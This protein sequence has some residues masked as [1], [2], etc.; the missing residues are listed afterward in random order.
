[1]TGSALKAGDR[2]SGSTES[3]AKVKFDRQIVAIA[4][5]NHAHAIFSDDENIRKFAIANGVNPIAIW[6][7]PLPPVDAQPTLWEH[8]SDEETP[9]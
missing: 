8:M 1:M 7:L 4:K 6:E 3:M 2:R 5:V 9:K